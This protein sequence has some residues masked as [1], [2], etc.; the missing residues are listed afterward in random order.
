MVLPPLLYPSFENTRNF[1]YSS[2]IG[3]DGCLGTLLLRNMFK[4]ENL[5]LEKIIDVKF[6]FKC[7]K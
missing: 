7:F 6:F 1:L 4:N 5:E 3:T 2:F